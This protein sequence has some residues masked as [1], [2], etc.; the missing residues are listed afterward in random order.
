M[1]LRVSMFAFLAVFILVSSVVRAQEGGLVVKTEPRDSDVYIDEERKATGTPAVIRLPAGTYNLTVR[2]D[3]YKEVTSEVEIGRDVLA[4][5]D[6]VLERSQGRPQSASSGS[7]FIECDGCPQMIVIP[8]GRFYMGDLTGGGDKDELPVR[9]VAI[10]TRFAIGRHEVTFDE[11]K[12]CVW[13]GGCSEYPDDEGWGRGDRPVINVSWHDAQGYVAWLSEATGEAYRLPSE[14]E[15]EYA[16]RAGTRTPFFTGARISTSQAKFDGGQT[17]PVGSFDANPWGLFDMHGNVWEWV[18]DCWH[19]DY[20]GAPVDGSAWLEAEGGDCSRRVLRGG[21][22]KD[23][24][25]DLRS[26]NRGRGNSVDRY[27][28]YGFRVARTLTP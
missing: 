3:G 25:R 1:M 23:F 14:A 11:Y 22:W 20:D 7:T 8:T 5:K 17:M 12:I 4:T 16:A 13:E 28:N 18:E 27:W 6:I 10:E 21:S 24:P 26:A 2:R 15:W 19:Y 9:A